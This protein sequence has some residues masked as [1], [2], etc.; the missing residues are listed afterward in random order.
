MCLSGHRLA[1]RSLTNSFQTGYAAQVLY[2]LSLSLAKMGTLVF[3][4]TI[5]RKV[6]TYKIVMGTMGFTLLWTIASLFGILFQCSVP[7]PWAI[8]SSQCFNQVRVIPQ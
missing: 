4:K 7:Q 8:L 1:L 5:A 3:V 2:I 6:S